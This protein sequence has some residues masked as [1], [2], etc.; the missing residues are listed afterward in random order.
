MLV[1]LL[2]LLTL[3]A[4]V[5]DVPGVWRDHTPGARLLAWFEIATAIVAPVLAVVLWTH[6]SRF[7]P[8]LW[9]WATTG[10]LQGGWA[11]FIYAPADSRVIAGLSALATC[12]VVLGAMAW[13]ARR[14]LARDIPER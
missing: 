3:V 11:A 5:N 6:A 10:T 1:V 12:I 2:V 7:E 4:A 9:T 14:W 13:Y 8:A